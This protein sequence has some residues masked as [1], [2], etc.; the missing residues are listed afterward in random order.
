M[1]HETFLKVVKSGEAETV[2]SMIA[3]D[4]ELA[5]VADEHGVTAL[6]WS[7]Y[8][9]HREVAQVLQEHRTTLSIFE[10]ASL[11][12]GEQ[13]KV[14]LQMD[15]SLS[16]TE[17]PD[18]FTALG[19]AAFF[20]QTDSAKVLL[21]FGADPNRRS[22][23]PIGAAPLH[24]ALSSGFVQLAKILMEHGADVNAPAAGGWTP[25]HYAAD[26]GDLELTKYLLAHGA[27]HGPMNQDGKN[28][29]E[30]ARDVGHDEVCQYLVEHAGAVLD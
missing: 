15:S 21:D 10:M 9:G 17:S 7:L 30:H 25:L 4:P 5:D 12:L 28:A 26:L 22:N 23:N 6:M 18:G 24:S 8:W 14:A 20:G 19:F 29:A 3:A 27:N 11:G 16:K 1:L 2:A 13:L